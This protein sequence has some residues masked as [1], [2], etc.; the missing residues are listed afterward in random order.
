M[1]RLLIGLLGLLIS[2]P[3]LAQSVQQSGTVTSG[4]GTR[5]ITS[6]VIGDAGSATNSNITELG[7]T[8]NGGIPFS[9]NSANTGAL[10]RLYGSVTSGAATIG[11]TS[12]GGASNG[13]LTFN[14]NG[15]SVTLPA[16]PGGTILPT[17]T[18]T[19]TISDSAPVCFDGTGG[20]LKNC[21]GTPGTGTVTSIAAGTGISASPDPITSAGTISLANIA[22]NTL[23]GNSSGGAAAPTVQSV[24]SGLALSSDTL[25][26]G[27]A[28]ITNAMLANVATNTLKGRSTAG[29][30]SPED[31]LVG[32]G[33]LL[34]GGV[35]SVTQSAAQ[36]ENRL[37]NASFAIGQRGTTFTSATTPANNDDTYLL[38]RW[39]L[40]SSGNDIVDVSQE[41]TTVPTGG[42]TAVLLDVETANQKFGLLQVI[43]QRNIAG[44]PGGTASLSFKARKGAANAT[45]TTMR[46]AVISWDGTANTVTSDIVSAW[47]VSGTD[48]TLVAN[49]TYENTPADLTLTD[50]Y[51]TFSIEGVSIDTPGT[52]NIGVF[53]WYNNADGTVGDL[54]YITDVQLV[55]GSSAGAFNPRLIN[56]DLAGCQ[57]Y[58]EKSY[59]TTTAP[60]T[61]TTTSSVS[62]TAGNTATSDYYSAVFRV[63]KRTTPAGVVYSTS[64]A[65]GNVRRVDNAT[66][67]AATVTDPGTTGMSFNF[68]NAASAS[69]K[70]HW[71]ADAE[72]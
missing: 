23:L 12:Q 62:F 14:M 40:L 44:I 2:F 13:T 55:A 22:N 27:T 10:T 51:Q 28:S 63:E 37:F 48:P 9:I 54:V 53:L 58:Y 45:V 16:A 15:S 1:K 49:W 39:I 46:A 57:R 11:V 31:I 24:G 47:N 60:G 67:V 65:S 36:P 30:G 43:E 32:S 70:L 6:G 72:L 69:F 64:G 5:W 34:S 4:H 7:I 25:S 29:T 41:T 52:N 42:Q 59:S 61:A 3:A 68:A 38:D 8:K 20:T 50:S 71:T 56:Q 21:G 19:P 17:V 33:L 66:N 35:L 26:V 18:T